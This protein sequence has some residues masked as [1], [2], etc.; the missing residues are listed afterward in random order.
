MHGNHLNMNDPNM[1]DNALATA[2]HATRC[3][4]SRSLSYQSPGALAFHRDMLLNIPLQSN[5]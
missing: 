1:V 2:M 3:A 5:L 4:A